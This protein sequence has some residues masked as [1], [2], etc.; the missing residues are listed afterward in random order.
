RGGGID[1]A[2]RAGRFADQLLGD[3]AR[4]VA[5]DLF[6][7]DVGARECRAG[8]D[9]SDRADAR[10]GGDVAV[11]PGE[12]GR[13]RTPAVVDLFV[14]R[15]HAAVLRVEASG[16]TEQRAIGVELFRLEHLSPMI[17]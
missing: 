10:A 16:V 5:R 17:D 7:A 1:R 8:G 13:A 6:G 3:A 9:R 11:I 2:V 4:L 14:D 15:A 12:A